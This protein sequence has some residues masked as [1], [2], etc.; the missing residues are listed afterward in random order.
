MS[1]SIHRSCGP[2]GMLHQ[3]S[4]AVITTD[5]PGQFI[6]LYP[7]A[8]MGYWV[9]A[10]GDIPPGEDKYPWAV[11]SA[12]HQYI[13]YILARD[14]HH[15][16]HHH[17]QHVLKWITDH[18]YTQDVNKPLETFQGDQCLY[19]PVIS[20]STPTIPKTPPQ[21]KSDPRLFQRANVNRRRTE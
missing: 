10:L 17:Q 4:G 5:Q 12:P 7:Q 6:I 16:R 15:F 11:I 14:V 9:V 19:P 20:Q 18:G 13:L 21:P 1:F 2:Q 3:A 8:A